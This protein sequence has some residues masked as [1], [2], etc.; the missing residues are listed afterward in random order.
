[1]PLFNELWFTCIETGVAKQHTSGITLWGI[2][3]TSFDHTSAQIPKVMRYK[4]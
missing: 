4:W 2:S 1:M 3:K